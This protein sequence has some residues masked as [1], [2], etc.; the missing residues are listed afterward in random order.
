MLQSPQPSL[1][2][3]PLLLVAT[4]LNS[5]PLS[6]L[7]SWYVVPSRIHPLLQLLHLK[8]SVQ[9]ATRKQSL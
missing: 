4:A 9:L 7:Q 6:P 2:L 5:F 1:R 8:V 3:P